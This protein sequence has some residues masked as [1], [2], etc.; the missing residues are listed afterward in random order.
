[1]SF[2]KPEILIYKDKAALY[3]VHCDWFYDSVAAWKHSHPQQE[4]TTYTS[5]LLAYKRLPKIEEL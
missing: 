3:C 2:K 4:I 1:M 5:R